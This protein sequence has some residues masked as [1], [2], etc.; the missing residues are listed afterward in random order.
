VLDG[1]ADDGGWTGR[2]RRRSGEAMEGVAAW[3]E[4]GGA[5]GWRDGGAAREAKEEE[6]REAEGGF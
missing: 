4:G 2:R 3:T 6:S 1:E 5:G